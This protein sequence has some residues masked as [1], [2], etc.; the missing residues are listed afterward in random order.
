M[1]LETC[2]TNVLHM[3][4]LEEYRKLGSVVI[5]LKLSDFNFNLLLRERRQ[6]GFV[7][8]NANLAVSGWVDLA[9]DR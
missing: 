7:T 4:F 3:T 6:L 5:F 2:V 1:I 9:Y 8:L